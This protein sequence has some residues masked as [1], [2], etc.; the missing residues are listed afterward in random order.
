MMNWGRIYVQ[1]LHIEDLA[2]EAERERL[3]HHGQVKRDES[4]AS[5]RLIGW[6]FSALFVLIHSLKGFR[7]G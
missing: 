1:Q 4:Y 2:R 5:L 7:L 6:A 3:I